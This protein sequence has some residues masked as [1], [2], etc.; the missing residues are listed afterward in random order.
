MIKLILIKEAGY[1]GLLHDTGGD[2]R[3]LFEFS[4]C[5]AFLEGYRPKLRNTTNRLFPVYVD[6]H[7]PLGNGGTSGG[8]RSKGKKVTAFFA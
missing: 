5:Y 6:N 7:C 4:L 8:S 2:T 1:D 3:F